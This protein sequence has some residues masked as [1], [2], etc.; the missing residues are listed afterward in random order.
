LFGVSKAITN[1]KDNRLKNELVIGKYNYLPTT[2]VYILGHSEPT[3][4]NALVGRSIHQMGGIFLFDI[5]WG[6][7]ESISFHY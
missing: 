2:V 7:S 6:S 5:R 4:N 3:T 1:I